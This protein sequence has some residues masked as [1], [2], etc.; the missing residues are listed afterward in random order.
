MLENDNMLWKLKQD[1]R[2]WECSEVGEASEEKVTIE[3]RWY[4]GQNE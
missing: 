1:K 2:D 3:P 4:L